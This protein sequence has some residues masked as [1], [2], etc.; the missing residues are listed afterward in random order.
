MVINGLAI[1]NNDRFLER[2]GWGYSQLARGGGGGGGGGMHPSADF[3]SPPSAGVLA[4]QVI[5]F[6]HAC[7]YL[8]VPL[9]P[10]NVVVI[11]VKLLF[12]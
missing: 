8:R 2:V 11:F 3:G 4:R 5:E 10:F 9:I 6:L 7:T 12:G 1:I